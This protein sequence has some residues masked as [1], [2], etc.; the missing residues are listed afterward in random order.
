MRGR[1][2]RQPARRAQGDGAFGRMFAGALNESFGG[3]FARPS[4]FVPDAA[5]REHRAL[6]CGPG[7]G[8]APLPHRRRRR[9]AADA[10]P[11][12]ARRVRSSSAPASAPPRPPSLLDTTEHEPARVPRRARLRRV[13]ARLPGEPGAALGL[14]PSS[15]ST[16]SRRTTTRPRSR[17]V[18]EIT[19]ADIG[20]DHGPL[21]RVADDAHGARARARGRP[22]GSRLAGDA[23]PA[24]RQ[25]STS[26]APGI[27]A[28]DAL[29]R[30][31]AST[32]SRPTRRRRPGLG[33]A[34]V[35]PALQ[36]YPSGDEPCGQP[37][38]PAGDVHVRRGV[39]P[40]PAQR[41]HPRGAPRGVR[42]REHDDASTR[43][44]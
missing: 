12:A 1:R 37:V 33:R 22:L 40:R 38:L 34:P 36:L 4:A 29:R 28:A 20:A 21:H 25:R 3:V 5:P 15:P 30:P 32:R 10:L 14:A 23:A 26:C 6:S 2:R 11:T 9:A 8:G 44:P 24:R 42:R 19:G 13:A 39:R 35:R 17:T 7:T 27:Y 43:S 16:T 31:R 18:R 41:R